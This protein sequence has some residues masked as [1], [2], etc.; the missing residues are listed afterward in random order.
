M[1]G[2]YAKFYIQL[3]KKPPNFVPKRLHQRSFLPCLRFRGVC[4]GAS[5]AVCSEV[6]QGALCCPSFGD[7]PAACRASAGERSNSGWAV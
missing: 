6:T 2:S 5:C 1:A 4:P 7:R 3:F